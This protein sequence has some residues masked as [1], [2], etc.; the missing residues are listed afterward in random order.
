MDLFPEGFAASN[1]ISTTNWLYKF[2]IRKTYK[3][4]PNK[5]IALGP[6]QKKVLDKK[7]QNEWHSKVNKAV[8]G[9]KDY[10]KN[11]K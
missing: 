7:Y 5:I 1:E 4:A 9:L 3:N 2:V 6:Q 11:K 10:L 8:F